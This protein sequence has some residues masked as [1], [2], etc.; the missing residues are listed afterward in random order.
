MGLSGGGGG[1]AEPGHGVGNINLFLNSTTHH[2]IR[3]TIY[4]NIVE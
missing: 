3:A 2:V 4:D 1:K